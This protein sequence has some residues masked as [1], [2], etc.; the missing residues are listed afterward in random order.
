MKFQFQ[1]LRLFM[2][3]AIL[4]GSNSAFAVGASFYQ[5]LV[6]N[7]PTL[8]N[9]PQ[10][11]EVTLQSIDCFG[12]DHANLAAG[13]AAAQSNNQALVCSSYNN[14]SRECKA[15]TRRCNENRLDCK[16]ALDIIYSCVPY[17]AIVDS[18]LKSAG[19]NSA[20]IFSQAQAAFDTKAASCVNGAEYVQPDNHLFWDRSCNDYA[21]AP[22]SFYELNEAYYDFNRY[23]DASGKSIE[24][25]YKADLLNRFALSTPSNE[26]WQRVVASMIGLESMQSQNPDERAAAAK[27]LGQHGDFSAAV[28]FSLLLAL[29]DRTA[30]V[31]AE[32]ARALRSQGDRKPLV[33][34]SLISRILD[35][36]ENSQVRGNAAVALREQAV[37]FRCDKGTEVDYVMDGSED[38]NDLINGIPVCYK[39]AD[40]IVKSSTP[41]DDYFFRLINNQ[42]RCPTNASGIAHNVFDKFD[43]PDALKDFSIS[44]NLCF[45]RANMLPSKLARITATALLVATDSERDPIAKSQM[46]AAMR[47]LGDDVTQ[48]LRSTIMSKLRTDYLVDRDYR[49]RRAAVFSLAKVA[50]NESWMLDQVIPELLAADRSSDVRRTAIAALT[51]IAPPAAPGT[52]VTFMSYNNG[53]DYLNSLATD[54]LTTK[55]AN[56][57]RYVFAS[58]V[59]AD[60]F[61]AGFSTAKSLAIANLCSNPSQPKLVSA[62]PQAGDA[63]VNTN[64]Q[65]ITLTFANEVSRQELEQGIQL[66]SQGKPIAL[67]VRKYEIIGDSAPRS[68]MITFQIGESLRSAELYQIKLKK[69]LKAVSPSSDAS[70]S[71]FSENVNLLFKTSSGKVGG[72][73]LD[74]MENDPSTDVQFAA[75]EAFLLKNE[76]IVIEFLIS[77]LRTEP[78]RTMSR[79]AS[80]LTSEYVS[81]LDVSRMNEE[82]QIRFLK[83]V[84]KLTKDYID[85]NERLF[86]PEP[87]VKD[88]LAVPAIQDFYR[89]M[90]SLFKKPWVSPTVKKEVIDAL[91][92]D[93]WLLKKLKAD[94]PLEGRTYS[95]YE[96]VQY[97]PIRELLKEIYDESFLQRTPQIKNV[98][99]IIYD[100]SLM[101]ETD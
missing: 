99:Y 88:Y 22:L 71:G 25:G 98:E 4:L 43:S 45:H 95:Y 28:K 68:T 27:M 100:K 70:E 35:T 64:T 51:E 5:C 83:E 16:E 74:M 84:I 85:R 2:A 54:C 81:F 60:F 87:P 91:D 1:Q 57:V 56:L 77:R 20:E 78:A 80:F 66:V 47:S 67:T 55:K 76:S 48:D 50:R 58:G 46:V 63:D 14:L 97:G 86:V 73:L 69:G 34:L 53:M 7:L 75:A 96:R 10:V 13:M 65:E 3:I 42:E 38:P 18:T 21:M 89:L 82:D 41:E 30:A 94:F 15:F 92:L 8:A 29:E 37:S 33:V 23:I 9:R 17:V 32:A 36:S 101:R 72:K 40:N 52:D 31:R 62:K 44:E 6:K 59:N 19:I 39:P 26:R 61:A 11:M 79:S 24:A 12:P 93:E 90:G 49:I